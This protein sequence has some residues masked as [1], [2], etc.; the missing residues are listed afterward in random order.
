MTASELGEENTEKNEDSAYKEI[1]AKINAIK[2]KLEDND[3]KARQETTAPAAQNTDILAKLEQHFVAIDEKLAEINKK[4]SA[5]DV[6]SAQVSAAEAKEK[7]D[8]SKMSTA[9]RVKYF[10]EQYSR[11][12]QQ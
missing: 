12:G 6:G 8:L 2:E 7:I 3:A 10:F 1:S 4:Q 5:Y 11:E 9:E